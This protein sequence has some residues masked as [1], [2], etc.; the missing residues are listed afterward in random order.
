MV[1]QQSKAPIELDY[2]KLQLQL[3]IFKKVQV[4]EVQGWVR[5]KIVSQKVGWYIFAL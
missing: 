2:H 1:V 3:K 5:K 4:Q